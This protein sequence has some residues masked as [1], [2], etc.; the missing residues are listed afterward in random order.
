MAETKKHFL[1][2]E[3]SSPYYCGAE[4]G[5]DNYDSTSSGTPLP[6]TATDDDQREQKVYETAGGEGDSYDRSYVYGHHDTSVCVT[7]T[8]T[9]WRRKRDRLWLLQKI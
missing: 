3:G 5:L 9:T 4:R 2:V 6:T 1:R 8:T 7:M